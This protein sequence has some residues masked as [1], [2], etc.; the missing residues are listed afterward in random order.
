MLTIRAD[1]RLCG[2]RPELVLACVITNSL[3]ERYG[4]D[5]ELT[6]GIEGKHSRTSLHHTGSAFDLILKHI[7]DGAN[8]HH[9]YARIRDALSAA[10]SLDFDVVFEDNPIHLHIEY[11]PKRGYVTLP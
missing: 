6:G 4:Y 9:E 1:V 5:G 10:L 3:L 2:F 7:P 8:V 11:Q